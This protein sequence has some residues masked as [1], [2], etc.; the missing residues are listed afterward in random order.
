MVVKILIVTSSGLFSSKTTT[1]TSTIP[2]YVKPMASKTI[3]CHSGPCLTLSEYASQPEVYFT[4]NTIFYFYPGIH[5]LG[6]SLRLKRVYNISFQGLPTSD[7]VVKVTMD[8]VARITWEKSCNISISSI[9]FILLDNFTFIIQ[10]EQSLFIQLSNISF[11]GNGQSGCSSVMSRD[12]ALLIHNSM[13]S[14]IRGLF[15]TALML[16]A[17]NVTVSGTSMFINNMAASGGSIYSSDSMLILDGATHFLNNTSSRYSKAMINRK[18][19][20]CNE[21]YDEI[22]RTKKRAMRNGGAIFCITSY[23]KINEYSS[24]TG[25]GANS[26]GGAI[27]VDTGDFT[28]QGNAIFT[29]NTAYKNGGAI[30]L[31]N[32]SSSIIGNLSLIDNKA[33]IGGGISVIKGNLIIQG[34]AL[35]NK[36]SANKRGG[37][38]HVSQATF[39]FCGSIYYGDNTVNGKGGALYMA[40]AKAAFNDKSFTYNNINATTPFP[41][42]ATVFHNNKGKGGSIY[43]W[44]KTSIQFFEIV[45]VNESR[46]SAIIINEYSNITFLGTTYFYQNTGDKGGAIQNSDS[47]V[48]FSGTVHFEKNTANFGGAMWL[49]RTSK[50]ILKPKLSMHFLLNHANESGGALYFKD[51]Q[52]FIVPIECFITIGGSSASIHNISLYFID[53]SA[54][55]TG[56]VLYGGQFDKCRLSFRTN[57]NP[58]IHICNQSHNTYSD[59]ALRELLAISTVIDH[60]YNKSALASISSPAVKVK[61]CPLQYSDTTYVILSKSI[62]PGEQFNY[63]VVAL[64]QAGYPVP[65]KLLGDHRYTGDKYRLSPTNHYINDTCTIVSFR[66]YSAVDRTNVQLK[67]YQENPCQGLVNGIDLFIQ[68]R[69]CPLGFELSEK[70]HMCV[71]SKK[72]KKFIQTCYIDN[73]SFE[74]SR[75]KFWISQKNGTDLIFHSFRC[76]LDYCK[77]KAVNVTLKY[78]SIQCDFNRDGVLCGQCQKN[79]SLALGSLHCIPC[80]NNHATLVVCFALA[81]VSLVII[82]F[83]FRLTV[84]F[85][86]MNGLFFFANIVQANHQAFFPRAKINFFTIFISWLNLDFGIETCFYDGLDIYA[87][88]WFQFLFPFYVWFLVGCIIVA[89]HY[90]RSFAKQLGQNPVAV[91]ATLFLM[92]YSKLLQAIIVPLSW[93]YLTLYGHSNETQNVVWLYDASIYFFKESKHIALG[94]FA[95][96]SIVLFV[97]PYIFLLL[98]GHWLQGCSN[99]WILSWLNKLKPFMDAYYA[100]YKKH[101]R[102]WTGLLLL[103]R[104]GLFLT[105]A[106]NANGSESVNILAVSSV[107]I[108]LLAIH[109]RIY[110]H[111]WKDFLESSFILN[112]GIFSVATFY[113]KEESEDVNSQLILSSISVGTSFTI[114]LGILLFH[115]S[116]VLK[117][118]SIWKDYIFPFIQRLGKLLRVTTDKDNVIA[119]NV[120][121]TALHP[122]PT[123]TE[124]AIDLNKPLLEITADTATY[125]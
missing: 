102:Y 82:I 92:S 41:R 98:F 36:N 31:H 14:K 91:L 93:T 115:I 94:F 120:E 112:L 52:C 71:C 25:N 53:N 111:W 26:Y 125:N 114:F 69:A 64:G 17:S 118:S 119:R 117:S 8:S 90:S 11:V 20:L 89:C 2:N 58:N 97:L 3:L 76:P 96:T 50:L 30:L 6:D 12:S 56:S 51:S 105:F 84:P 33:S 15:G 104:L 122:L 73:I 21:V 1:A 72:V 123:T 7:E 65:A 67:L 42:Y 10:F 116:L 9:S 49:E 4:N 124:V 55:S 46:S 23:L 121:A 80:D 54:K 61:F 28:I 47:N 77:D 32:T 35:F 113:L 100:P 29:K 19:L 101:A 70:D 34:Y 74:R 40:K 60:I 103:T 86:T 44:N 43:C 78:P 57:C 75:N 62:Y 22:V 87:Y 85:G 110:E 38:M 27:L 106:I 107:S 95:I 45:N 48:M 13:F 63:S 59:H 39:K 66:L 37:A 24:F 68:V 81:G 88:S 99:W 83:I 109:R 18:M 16:L 108:A 79:F 5:R